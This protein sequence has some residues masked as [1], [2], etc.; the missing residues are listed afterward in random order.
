MS[1]SEGES[2]ISEQ[3]SNIIFSDRD[4]LCNEGQTVQSDIS[5]TMESCDINI[6]TPGLNRSEQALNEGLSASL[7]TEGQYDAA[8]MRE[9]SS[10]TCGSSV[11]L[12][13]MSNVSFVSNVQNHGVQDSDVQSTNMLNNDSNYS[14]PNVNEHL[15]RLTSDDISKDVEGWKSVEHFHRRNEL[16]D[17]NALSMNEGKDDNSAGMTSL[18]FIGPVQGV[19]M[20]SGDAFNNQSTQVISSVCVTYCSLEI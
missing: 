7:S 2:A 13:D 11:S 3:T 6:Q 20:T 8:V 19:E 4:K 17:Q 5:N 10:E 18:K 16:M 15:N 1:S 9:G 14:S 12:V